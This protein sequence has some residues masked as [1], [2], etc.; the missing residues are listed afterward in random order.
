M[1]NK[2][3]E[4]VN[5][6]HQRWDAWRVNFDEKWRK[7]GIEALISPCQYH[8]AFKSENID[9]AIIHDYYMIWNFTHFP[10]GVIPVTAVREEEAQGTYIADTGH[11]WVDKTARSIQNSEKGSTGMPLGVQVVTQ[12]W[13]D[14]ECVALMKIVDDAI[15][16]FRVPLPDEI[17]P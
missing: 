4:G 6:L 15:G 17:N 9:L 5:G 12:Q 3:H 11:R 1:L 16:N 14:E 10:A 7:A 13:R 2:D 8:C